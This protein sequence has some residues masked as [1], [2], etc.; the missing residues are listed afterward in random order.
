ME[1]ERRSF[2][3]RDIGVTK[4]SCSPIVPSNV[5]ELRALIVE[6]RPRLSRHAVRV[7]EFSMRRPEEVAFGTLDSVA[8]AV[9]VSPATVHRT[10]KSL[11]LERFAD[12]RNMFRSVVRSRASR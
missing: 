5:A 2:P 9:E 11:G 12:F 6:G 10:L 4:T 7:I 8:H 1:L 3:I